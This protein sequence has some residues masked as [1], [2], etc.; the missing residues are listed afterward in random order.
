MFSFRLISALTFGLVPL[1]ADAE[2]MAEY[3]AKIEFK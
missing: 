3:P 2:T 1:V